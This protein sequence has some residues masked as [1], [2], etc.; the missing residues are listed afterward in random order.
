MS[1]VDH[2]HLLSFAV[3]AEHTS[4]THAARAMGL[5][6]PALF[7]QVK[8]LED[9]VGVP[10]YR[11]EGRGLALTAEGERV[12][13]WGREVRARTDDLVRTLRGETPTGPVVLAAGRGAFLHLLGPAVKRG[14]ASPRGLRLL[15][16]PGA[17]AA[18]A[19]RDRKADLAV[20]AAPEHPEDLVAEDVCSV[21]QVVVVPS[22]DA[23]A[24]RKRVAPRDLAR[25]PCVLPPRGGPQR[26][27]IDALFAASGVV[28]SPAVEASGWDL[29]LH[30][31]A[32]GLGWAIVNDLCAL[33]RG[34]VGVPLA[35]APRVTYR[36]FRRNGALSPDVQALRASILALGP[37]RPAARSTR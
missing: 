19:V 21:G 10:L 25:S 11:R 35:G 4:F 12:A 30:F 14:V 5:S 3:F 26:A 9:A 2:D 23:L 16:S 27:A 22:D 24:R 29:A 32:C 20:S 28:L 31:V 1:Q 13:A 15:P 7:V 33:P 17:L 6:Q 18:Q 34:F 37:P 8:K 36:L